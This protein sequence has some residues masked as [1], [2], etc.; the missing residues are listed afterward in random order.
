MA[1]NSA[2]IVRC[3]IVYNSIKSISYLNAVMLESYKVQLIMGKAQ[4]I[5]SIV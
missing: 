4:N 5:C 2:R 3:N 1:S